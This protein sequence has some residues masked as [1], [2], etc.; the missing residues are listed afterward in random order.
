MAEEIDGGLVPGGEADGGGADAASRRASSLSSEWGGEGGA[1]DDGVGLAEGDHVSEGGGE[2]VEE[3]VEGLAGDLGHVEGE[4]GGGEAEEEEI[5]AVLVAGA[6]GGGAGADVEEGVGLEESGE[7]DGV[8]AFLEHP[9]VEGLDALHDV[10]GGV[11]VEEG[12]LDVVDVPEHGVLPAVAV[13]LV[14]FGEEHVL[15]PGDD[16]SGDGAAGADE[17]FGVGVDDEVGAFLLVLALEG[18]G[19]EGGADGGVEDDADAV[20]VGELAHGGNVE[21]VAVGLQGLSR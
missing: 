1:G 3:A 10:E 4:E 19:E 2:E 21:D 7:D 6:A 13:F 8:D 17:V 9:G 20:L 5:A 12:A 11:G 16:A 14:A 18:G 15:V